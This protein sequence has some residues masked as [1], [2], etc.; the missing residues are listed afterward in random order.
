MALHGGSLERGTA[1]VARRAARRLRRVALRR[2]A[3]RRPAVAHP[4]APVRPGGRARTSAAFL[5]HVEVVISVHGYGREGWWTRLLVGG[6]N[7]ELAARAADTLREP[8]R[9]LRG[10][11][12]HR[13]DP[14]RAAGAASRQPGEPA[15]LRAVSSSSSRRGCAA[16]GRTAGP[17]SWTRWWAGSPRSSRERR[18]WPRATTGAS[19]SGRRSGSATSRPAAVCVSTR[20]PAICRTSPPTTVTTRALPAGAGWILRR[21]DLDID[22]LPALADELVLETRCT[23]V[24]PGARWAE[25]T[26]TIVGPGTQPR[27]A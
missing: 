26:T 13:R 3:A 8:S 27:L 17:S 11:R 6:A 15:P 19:A 20:S 10:A 18:A 2:R 21:V 4:V 12:R 24:G 1:E 14:A 25:R 16:S 9:R 7:R 22:R 5:D 23:G